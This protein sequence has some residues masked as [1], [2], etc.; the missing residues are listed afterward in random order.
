MMLIYI[1]FLNSINVCTPIYILHMYLFNFHL[2]TY[3]NEKFFTDLT[4]VF[5]RN[6]NAID[7]PL[8]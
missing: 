7:I 6:E 1:F 2:R 5:N 4:D 8:L 3:G